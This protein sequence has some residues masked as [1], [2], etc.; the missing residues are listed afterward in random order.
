MFDFTDQ[1]VGVGD[2]FSSTPQN[3][4]GYVLLKKVLNCF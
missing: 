1:R 2:I 4:A 3:A